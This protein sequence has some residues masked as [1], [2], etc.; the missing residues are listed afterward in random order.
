ML[1]GMSVG[2]ITVW[3]SSET[4]PTPKIFFF[5]LFCLDSIR[6]SNTGCA[7]RASGYGDTTQERLPASRG[8]IT[9]R[10]QGGEGTARRAGATCRSRAGDRVVEGV[11]ADGAELE[12]H[13]HL[14]AHL[15]PVQG[16]GP[17][18][19]GPQRLEHL[20]GQ[21]RHRVGRDPRSEE[22]R[23]GKECR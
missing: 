15:L 8:K 7:S 11:V 23:V 9:K 3:S 22:R 21:R 4:M 19:R 6:T 18:M 16:R 2:A 17:E 14:G 13:L 10:L 20:V 5:W 12:A 1:V